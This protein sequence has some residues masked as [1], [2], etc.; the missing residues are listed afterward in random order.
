MGFDLAWETRHLMICSVF[1]LIL[2]IAFKYGVEMHPAR[3]DQ[4][5]PS[6]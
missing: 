3:R 4:L 1:H 6:L 5:D 2:I